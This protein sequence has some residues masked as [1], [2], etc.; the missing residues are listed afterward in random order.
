MR[1]S[2]FLEEACAGA[3]NLVPTPTAVVRTTLQHKIGGYCADLPHSGDMAMWMKF[4]AH[5]DVGFLNA[6]QAYYRV[7]GNNMHILK[8]GSNIAE[9][10]ERKK[11]FDSLFRDCASRIRD[12]DRLRRSAMMVI[13][14]EALD[15]AYG[16]FLGRDVASCR[17]LVEL[18]VEACPEA[19]S[20][21][22]CRRLQWMLHAG[23]GLC[24]LFR[25]LASW[26]RA[27]QPA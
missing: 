24:L 18:A 22:L 14:R 4:A 20:W 6:D 17:D 21:R 11:A 9:K 10:R 13:A 2:D 1:G 26:C 15:E 8:F 23:P 12:S 27:G 19:R 5:A 3:R 16:A 7:H 25:R